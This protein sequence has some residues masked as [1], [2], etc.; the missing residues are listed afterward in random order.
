MNKLYEN[1]PNRIVTPVIDEFDDLHIEDTH[2]MQEN[3]TIKSGEVKFF[4]E[5]N[6]SGNQLGML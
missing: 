3:I 4:S 1:D 2:F 6:V 5:Q